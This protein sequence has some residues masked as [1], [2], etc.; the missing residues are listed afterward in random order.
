MISSL[1]RDLREFG[2]TASVLNC[3]DRGLEL[4]SRIKQGLTDRWNEVDT[5]PKISID[6]QKLRRSLAITR[7]RLVRL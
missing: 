7:G 3:R 5:V 2:K 6:K 1:V 4:G